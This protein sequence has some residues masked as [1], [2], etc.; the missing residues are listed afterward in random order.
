[1]TGAT[2]GVVTDAFTASTFNTIMFHGLSK[3]AAANPAIY[4]GSTTIDTGT[5]YASRGSLNGGAD[6]TDV[7]LGYGYLRDATQS[8][9][10]DI[11]AIHYVVNMAT[12]EKLD[13][14]HYVTNQASGAGAAPARCEAI[15]K[16]ANTSNQ[17]DIVEH[18]SN[19]TAT[20][21]TDSN[22]TILGTD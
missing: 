12:E 20:D 22:L 11:F 3:S 8:I 2:D 1:M 17:F 21:A 16:W 19:G 6:A 7:S 14:C 5:N 4:F 18:G 13:Y 9:S 10:L 15:V